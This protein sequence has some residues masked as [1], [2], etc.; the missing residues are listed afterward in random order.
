MGCECETKCE[1]C[2]CEKEDDNVMGAEC[3]VVTAFKIEQDIGKGN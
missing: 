3:P 2:G 1:V